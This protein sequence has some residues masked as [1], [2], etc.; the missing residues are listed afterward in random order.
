[1]T[2]PQREGRAALPGVDRI[3]RS[4]GGCDLVG[5]YGRQLVVDAVRAALAER[6]RC[7]G[8]ATVAAVVD[9]T[10][11]SLA[12]IIQPSQRWVFN[13]TGTVLHTN[14]GRAPLPEEAIAAAAA[15][16]LTASA[17]SAPVRRVSHPAT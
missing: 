2:E 8:V 14:L 4:E 16:L 11:A 10:A 13:L 12:R 9:E 6:R 7:G 5:R 15:L 3:L 17:A 1:M